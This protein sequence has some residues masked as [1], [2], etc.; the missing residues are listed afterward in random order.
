MKIPVGVKNFSPLQ[1]FL[2]LLKT[3][4]INHES[5]VIIEKT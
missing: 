2:K 1:E 5:L 4:F 3:L